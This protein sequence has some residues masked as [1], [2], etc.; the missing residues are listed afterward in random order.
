MVGRVRICDENPGDLPSI[1]GGAGRNASKLLGGHRACGYAQ[2]GG[3]CAHC[4]LDARC[5]AVNDGDHDG[6]RGAR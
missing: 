6:Q 1:G 3:N 5:L 4:C 2:D